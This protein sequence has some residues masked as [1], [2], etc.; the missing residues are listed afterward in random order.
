[1]GALG[2]LRQI[3]NAGSLRGGGQAAVAREVDR[4][5]Q[6][7]LLRIAGR[8]NLARRTKTSRRRKEPDASRL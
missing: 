4:E 7:D 1:L 8:L 3:S 2:V 5:V 6:V